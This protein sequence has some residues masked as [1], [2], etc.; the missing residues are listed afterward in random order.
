MPEERKLSADSTVDALLKRIPSSLYRYSG[1]GGERLEWMRRLVVESELYFAAPSLFND[2]LDFKIPTSFEAP[3][4]V[5]EKHWRDLAQKS[6]A[7]MPAEEKEANIQGLIRDSGTS[8]GRKRL[9]KKLLGVL[10]NN[11]TAC[12]ATDPTNM[13]MWSYYADGHKG[14]AVRFGMDLDRILALGTAFKEQGTDLFPVEVEYE[15]AF[16]NCNYYTADKHERIK[17][18][19]GTK[20][21]AWKHEGEWRIV[22]PGRCDCYLKIPPQIITGVILGMRIGA[23]EEEAIRGWLAAKRSPRVELLRVVH[24]PNSFRLELAPA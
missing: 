6:F 4:D 13:L 3:G 11:G 21:A 9:E 5:I 22:L 15:E 7:S 14:A 18:V 1:L 12:F 20:S 19:L 17:V 10:A 2:P 16:P 23:K 8:D 24:K